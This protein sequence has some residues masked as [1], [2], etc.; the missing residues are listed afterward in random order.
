[1]SQ[2]IQYLSNIS[3]QYDAVFCDLW[4]CLH[5][6]HTPFPAAV[7]AL[8]TYRRAGGTVILVTNSPRPS[9]SVKAQLDG[10]HVPQ[11]CYD[12][13]ASSGD[14]AQFGFYGG[15]AGQKV[16]HIGPPHDVGFFTSVSAELNVFMAQNP[17]IERVDFDAAQGIVCT[18]PFNDS[19]DTPE[20]YR[21]QFAKAISR[22]MPMLCANPD[23]IV[24]RGDQ[25]IYCAGALAALYSQMGGL[26]LYYGKPHAPIYDLARRRLSQLQPDL[27]SPRAL[28][29]GDGIDTDI[30]GAMYQGI[31]SLFITSGIAAGNFGANTQNPEAALLA[32][33][34]AAQDRTTTFSI[35]FLR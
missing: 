19:V 18:G 10:M 1:M 15:A 35:G 20:D 23:I 26:S 21:D 24:D 11:D 34:L 5:N 17:T 30:L 31:D 22:N 8:Q 27:K 9:A 13:I 2:I 6:G 12:A 7:R 33:W 28:A 4:G 29:I 14:A 25:R 3:A 16:Y 32:P